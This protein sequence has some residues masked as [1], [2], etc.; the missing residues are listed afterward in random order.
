[1][2][3]P[4]TQFG[5]DVS[6]SKPQHPFTEHT[7][8]SLVTTAEPAVLQSVTLRATHSIKM[9]TPA[10]VGI[11]PITRNGGLSGLQILDVITI[12]PPLCGD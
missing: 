6:M 4:P 3:S 1:M 7:L 2:V 12:Q 5:H 11:M 9:Q 10:P 8:W